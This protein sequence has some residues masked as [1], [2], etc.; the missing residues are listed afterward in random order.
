M[1]KVQEKGF[2]SLS[3]SPIGIRKPQTTICAYF[4]IVGGVH[5]RGSAVLLARGDVPLL[6]VH[7]G[8]GSHILGV[9]QQSG[10]CLGKS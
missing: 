2:P 9:R 7:Q 3:T 10:V 6:V 5:V 1:V 4:G 8:Q